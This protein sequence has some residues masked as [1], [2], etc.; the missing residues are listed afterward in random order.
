MFFWSLIFKFNKLQRISYPKKPINKS[1]S[2]L[3]FFLENDFR[4]LTIFLFFRIIFL[5]KSV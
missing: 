1:V 5:E 3:Y 2:F 4:K